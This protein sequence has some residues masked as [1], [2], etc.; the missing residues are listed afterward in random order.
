MTAKNIADLK[1]DNDDD[2]K[3]G[4]IG[5]ILATTDNARRDDFI[6]SLLNVVETAQQ[7]LAG[8]IKFLGSLIVDAGFYKSMASFSADSSTTALGIKSIYRLTAISADTA[9]TLNT[10]AISTGSP[11]N[12]LVITIKDTSG[13][14]VG[15]GFTLTIATE[16]AQTIDGDASLVISADYGAVTLISDGTNLFTV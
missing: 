4:V 1:T 5:G 7:T 2:I 16:G 8:P 14:I 12:P 3:P 9:L 6:D 15:S 13:N 11:A 10:A